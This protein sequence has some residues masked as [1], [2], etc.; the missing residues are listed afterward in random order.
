MRLLLKRYKI[1]LINGGS[2]IV[3]KSKNTTLS[4]YK[5]GFI[6][7]FSLHS[8]IRSLDEWRAYLS[9]YAKNEINVVSMV[10]NTNRKICGAKGFSLY[11]RLASTIIYSLLRTIRNL[12]LSL[13]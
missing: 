11:K 10:N 3:I 6:G 9:L 12:L 5:K 1:E 8:F 2:S 7:L 13:Y 4:A